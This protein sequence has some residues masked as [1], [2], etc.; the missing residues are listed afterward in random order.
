MT[1]RFVAGAMGLP[2]IPT[3]SGLETD[4]VK[5]LGFPKK[6]AGKGKVPKKKLKV[7]QNPWDEEDGNVVILPALESR[8]GP[9]PCPICRGRRYYSD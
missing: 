3:K 9:A 8:C 2:F 1:L 4:I 7:M 5:V 6:F